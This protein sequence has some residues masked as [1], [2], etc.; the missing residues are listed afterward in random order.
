M[1]KFIPALFFCCL[2]LFFGNTA[3][4]NCSSEESELIITIEPD[5]FFLEIT[6]R[7]KDYKTG[8]SILYGNWE[9][10]TY[11]LPKDG[12]YDFTIFD[13]AGDGICC[14][15]FGIQGGYSVHYEGELII[16]GGDYTDS[17]YSGAFGCDNGDSCSDS[18]EIIGEGVYNTPNPET[19]YT[20][21]PEESG[22]YKINTCFDANN[23]NTAIWV[24]DYCQ[25]LPYTNN[26]QGSIKF[27]A[28]GCVNNN[29]LA[30]TQLNLIEGEKYFIRVGHIEECEEVIFWEL[31]YLAP[32]TDCD[33]PNACNYNPFTVISDPSSCEYAG[34]NDDCPGPD[35]MIDEEAIK[36]SMYISSF[37]SQIADCYFQEGCVTGVGLREVLRFDTKIYNVGSEDFYLGRPDA[38]NPLWVWDSC[39]FHYHFEEYA[40]Y[41]L[42]DETNA[43]LP[44]GRKTGFCLE[45]TGC[46]NLGDYKFSCISQ[47]LTA[48]C[49]DL[50]EAD[51]NCQWLDITDV[52][53]GLY[54]LVVRVN[55]GFV[56]D[57]LGRYEEDYSNNWA[58][59]CFELL[60]DDEGVASFEIK[61]TCNLIVDCYGEPYGDAYLDCKGVCNGD[62]LIGDIIENEKYQN[63]DFNALSQYII[64]DGAYKKC[65][66]PSGNGDLDMYDLTLLS[67]CINTGANCNFPFSFSNSESI[68]NFSFNDSTFLFNSSK[69]AWTQINIETPEARIMAYELSV[70]NAMILD[71]E[72][73]IGQNDASVII[74]PNKDKLT[75]I[76]KN[77]FIPFS[78]DPLGI[79]NLHLEILDETQNICFS[80]SMNAVNH[81]LQMLSAVS[82]ANCMMPEIYTSNSNFIG[83]QEYTIYTQDRQLIIEYD[84]GNSF[85]L[86]IYDLNG[87]LV[88]RIQDNKGETNILDLNMLANGIYVVEL[89]DQ[90]ELFQQKILLH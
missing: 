52:D 63:N 58:Q 60:R 9:G 66:D 10:G 38:D 65:Y 34:G 48:G 89:I 88:N 37:N 67:N 16:E 7:V 69:Q 17:E 61:E 24:Y 51:Y 6:W 42:F 72:L 43:P 46:P 81:Q 82:G 50:Y 23:C 84:S 3:N 1:R 87:R 47:G 22:L 29:E 68:V 4:A 59:V 31:S 20:F 2:F 26:L 56:P 73:L 12:C 40:E 11:C 15:E 78:E 74:D 62:A 64:D 70:E 86:N 25:G 14:N 35:F 39:H 5:A 83:K 41:I 54:T 27:S 79:L 90:N 45:D 71:Y 44:L 13:L 55:W 8:E 80:E 19:W 18:F 33:D 77:E 32:V 30:V 36:S 85:T 21:S 76:Y 57:S 49:Y 53:A 28:N 75:V